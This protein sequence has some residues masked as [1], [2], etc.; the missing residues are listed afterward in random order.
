[1][2]LAVTGDALLKLFQQVGRGGRRREEGRRHHDAKFRRN[3]FYIQA[4]STSWRL[5][6]QSCKTP[7]A[8]DV[9]YFTFG[10]RSTPSLVLG[11]TQPHGVPKNEAVAMGGDVAH[12]GVSI[13]RDQ[14]ESTSSSDILSIAIWSRSVESS[15]ILLRV[16]SRSDTNYP[17]KP[18]HSTKEHLSR[19]MAVSIVLWEV[20]EV[21]LC[22][23]LARRGALS[24][25]RRC[26]SPCVT[27]DSCSCSV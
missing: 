23:A 6:R 24:T 26:S 10:R 16:F 11:I 20:L 22:M 25:D 21:R 4:F 27:N 5:M 1:M 15:E 18:C 3:C 9:V 14:P 17:N 7:K 19:T 8:S 2:G 12:T 13:Q